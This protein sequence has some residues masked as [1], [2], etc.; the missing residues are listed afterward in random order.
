MLRITI[1][2]EQ[3]KPYGI[4]HVKTNKRKLKP[5]FK[6]QDEGRGRNLAYQTLRRPI[7]LFS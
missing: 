5:K 7:E 1:K 3:M 4:A 2:T 6:S